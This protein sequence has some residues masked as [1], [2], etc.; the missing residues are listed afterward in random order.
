[1]GRKE[2]EREEGEGRKD[3]VQIGQARSGARKRREVRTGRSDRSGQ[4]AN[5]KKRNKKGVGNA[6][7]TPPPLKKKRKKKTLF[8]LKSGSFFITK[9]RID[10]PSRSDYSIK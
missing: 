7:L 10:F 3:K 1:M 8:R 9:E 6:N 2:R 5:K 4:E